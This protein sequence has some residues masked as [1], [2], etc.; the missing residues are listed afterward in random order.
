MKKSGI[1][2]HQ[3]HIMGK[4]ECLTPPHII[5]KYGTRAKSNSGA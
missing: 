1:G 2:S 3:S 4:D 5:E